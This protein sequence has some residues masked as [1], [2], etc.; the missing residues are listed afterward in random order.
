MKTLLAFSLLLF[1][2]WASAVANENSADARPR[3]PVRTIDDK[4]TRVAALFLPLEKGDTP[5]A[6][7]I[8]IKEGRVLLKTGYGVANLETGQRITPD[9]AFLLASVTKQFTAMAV[10]ILAERGK[11]NYEDSLS[12]FFPRFP[13]FA[14]E[15]TVRK[16]LNHTAGLPEYEGLFLKQRLI[17][18]DWPRSGKSQRSL[19]EPTSKDVL[20]LLAE[21]K[22]LRFR[23]GDKFEYSNSGY[24]VLA[25]IVEKVSGESF[26]QFLQQNIFAPLGMKRT[27]LYDETRP[28]LSNVAISY[29]LKRGVYQDVDYAPLNLIYGEDNIYTTVEDMARWD[30]ALS[31]NTLVRTATL[32]EAFTPGKLNNGKM[33]QY[34]MVEGKMTYY[35][36]GWLIDDDKV[37]HPGGWL[38]YRTAIVRFPKKSLSVVILSNFAKCHPFKIAEKISEIYL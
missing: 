31:T 36:F 15:I 27:L 21:E 19:F 10:M 5:G 25:Q 20:K 1:A 26:S 29:M 9:T 8:V 7:V 16:L 38:G 24:V 22:K 11:L 12:K 18:R 13:S 23:P 35:G 32:K 30:R 33:A 34:G 17:D 6:A 3:S 4:A 14:R 28:K 2:S 37:Y